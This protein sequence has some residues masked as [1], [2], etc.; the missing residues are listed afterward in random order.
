MGDRIPADHNYRL[1]SALVEQIP[2][3]KDLDWQ[4]GTIT[5]IPD[6]NGWIKLGRKSILSVRC[7]VPFIPLFSVLS[8]QIIRIGQTLLQLG[9]MEGG[10]LQPQSCLQSRIVTV[11]NQEG[12]RVEPFEFGIA[13]GKQ[14]GFLGVKCV[15]FLGDRCTLKIKDCIV[16]GYR[17]RF[18]GLEPMESLLLQTKGIGGRRR[19]GCGVFYG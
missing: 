12:F 17:L 18:E 1:Y 11:R 5:G 14:L 6:R 4:L 19:M 13:I 9:E 10:T 3:L 8:C 2:D 16:V 7:T 15:P